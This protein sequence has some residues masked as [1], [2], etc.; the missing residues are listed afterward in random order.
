MKTV[1][2]TGANRSI[3]LETAKQ[4]SEKG[5]FVYLGSRNLTK[6]EETIKDLTEQGFQNIKA[7]EIDVTNPE[8]V[9]KAKEQIE[10]EQGKL[11]ILI[12]NAGI[13]GVIPQTA[14]HTAIEDIKA[15][16]ETNLF[17]AISVTQTFLELL[18]KSDQPRISNITSG[19]GSL[20]LHSDPS[21]KYYHVKNA[22]YGP[23][24]SALNAYTIVLAYELR[25]LPFKV[26][27][28]DP[29]YTATDFNHHNG[30][31]S[32]ESAASFIV[33]HTLTDENA[34]TGQYF[35]NDIEDEDG[36]SPW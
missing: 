15:V 29:G 31:G 1:L 34:P 13:L 14:E 25:D 17:G 8:S 9:L 5:L 6:G 16:F 26:N 23:S 18:K 22:A 30:P 19:L 7:V 32:I 35:S 33:K 11:D 10:D 20:T 4:L 28:I 27:V 24:K 21:W 3:G 12:N 36:I 2:I